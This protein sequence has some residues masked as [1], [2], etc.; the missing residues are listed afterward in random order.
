MLLYLLLYRRDAST[1]WQIMAAYADLASLR[2]DAPTRAAGLTAGQLAQA[3]IQAAFAI[4]ET[5]TLT[6]VPLA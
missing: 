1:Q 2:A 5:I 6:P 4:T 3:V